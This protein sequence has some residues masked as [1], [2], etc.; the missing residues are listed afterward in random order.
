MK[1]K[2]TKK[3]ARKT[4]TARKNHKKRGSFQTGIKVGV[5]CRSCGN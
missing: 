5:S 2:N 1:P 3:T 4:V